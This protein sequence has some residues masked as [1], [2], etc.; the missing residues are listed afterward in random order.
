MTREE[1]DLLARLRLAEKESGRLRALVAYWQRRAHRAE[2][3]ARFLHGIL[4]LEGVEIPE[5]LRRG[6]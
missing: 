2:D 3:N 4:I 1:R 6:R 5:P